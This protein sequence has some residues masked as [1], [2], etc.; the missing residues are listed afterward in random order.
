MTLGELE[1]DQLVEDIID[2]FV[3]V[4][5]LLRQGQKLNSELVERLIELLYEYGNASS[6]LSSIP[7][8]LAEVF[9]DAYPSM[10]D[11]AQYA[12]TEDSREIRDM[13]ERIGEA[14]RRVLSSEAQ[15]DT[16]RFSAGIGSKEHT[17][18]RVS[19]SQLSEIEARC[20]T[21]TPGP[22]YSYIEGRDHSSG[23]SFIMTGDANEH[24]DGIYLIGATIADHDFIAHARQDIP[25]LL[26]EVRYLRELLRQ[27]GCEK[28]QE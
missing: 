18:E 1:L 25:N 22:W 8:K 7:K 5:S 21:C 20:N 27:R 4:T 19:E 10:L 23:D 24:G 2:T 17:S 12:V 11:F 28:Q 6:A 9:V 16:L 3:Q 26:R 15:R 14:I 13:H